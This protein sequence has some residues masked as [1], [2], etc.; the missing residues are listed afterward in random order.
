[1]R[2]TVLALASAATVA[3]NGGSLAPS[4]ALD[5]ELLANLP[6]DSTLIAGADLRA[7]RRSPLLESWLE[8]TGT[9]LTSLESAL[10]TETG[11]SAG[12]EAL[13]AVSVGCGA[14]GCV[15]SARGN[16]AGFSPELAAAS[17]NRVTAA[18]GV[19]PAE[20]VAVR[21]GGLMALEAKSPRG[22]SIAMQLG[23]SDRAAFGDASA[24]AAV[25]RPE[26]APLDAS[27]L[28]GTVPAGDLWLVM[29]DPD[30][31]FEHVAAR[32][33]Q[34]GSDRAEQAAA[35]LLSGHGPH[36]QAARLIEVVAFS[37]DVSDPTT[38]RAR[39]TCH[40][41]V[42]AVAVEKLTRTNLLN[43]SFASPREDVRRA[44]DDAVVVRS[45]RQ[46]E[47]SLTWDV[48]DVLA[49]LERRMEARR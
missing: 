3:C 26:A 7:V 4:Q 42:A 40:N 14:D 9:N 2:L 6:A 35:R 25:M 20:P 19:Q 13:T 1:M 47:V 8:L 33:R 22:E 37:A 41:A 39:A 48:E 23:G 46:V 18:V 24:V 36:R 43:L 17:I 16:L 28:E 30:R 44:A 49:V 29:H 10:Q 27:G 21:T 34:N 5:E 32:M 11:I 15:G 31:L 38:V 45:G 12:V